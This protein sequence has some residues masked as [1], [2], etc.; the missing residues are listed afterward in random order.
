MAKNFKSG[1]AK[2]AGHRA[3]TSFYEKIP[4]HVR[5]VSSSTKEQSQQASSMA[6]DSARES[7]KIDARR[8]R[9][10]ALHF[11]FER[12][13]PS[14]NGRQHDGVP[15]SQ[16]DGVIACPCFEPDQAT[17]FVRVVALFMG[18]PSLRSLQ[19]H[20]CLHRIWL[21]AIN[22]IPERWVP[23]LSQLSRRGLKLS[24]GRQRD[25]SHGN[26]VPRVGCPHL[27]PGLHLRVR[28]SRPRP[29]HTPSKVDARPR[30]SAMWG[31]NTDALLKRYRRG[32]G[33]ERVSL[34]IPVV[35]D[36][37]ANE[38][39]HELDPLPAARWGVSAL[40]VAYR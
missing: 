31:P 22:S 5:D 25:A 6:K 28:R 40:A 1:R 29:Q 16:G 13:A 30:P 8:R 2:S 27:P 10:E 34:L 26:A 23:D 3:K 7:G 11:R 32:L 38:L 24:R 33:E 36:D 17:P 4:G 18:R 9:M 21:D 12:S 20:R 19:G 37:L 39:E 35:L 14:T 15:R